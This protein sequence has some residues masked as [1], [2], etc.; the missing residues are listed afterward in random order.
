MDLNEYVLALE[1]GGAP[2][3]PLFIQIPLELS[4]VL[5]RTKE[6]SE[7]AVLEIGYNLSWN[8][9]SSKVEVFPQKFVGWHDGV[10]LNS[11]TAMNWNNYIGDFHVH[12]YRKKYGPTYSIGPSSGDWEGWISNFPNHRNFSIN[13][14]ASGDE[15]FLAVFTQ[16]PNQPNLIMDPRFSDTQ[17]AGPLI[18]DFANNNRQLGVDRSIFTQNG[19]WDD[20]RDLYNTH[21]PQFP[22]THQQ[23]VSEMNSAIAKLN[24]GCVFYEGKLNQ[25]KMTFAWLKEANWDAPT[26]MMA[27]TRNRCVAC[28]ATHGRV[29]SNPFNAWHKCTHCGAVYCPQHGQI[30]EGKGKWYDRTRKCVRCGERTSLA[31]MI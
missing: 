8:T 9:L 12:P 21:V 15:L 6:E 4:Q 26:A 27:L 11:N 22:S 20:L 1:N 30:L 18:Q 23:D 5:H 10:D 25:H 16:R 24:Y 28:G 14:V 17:N 19:R 31:S 7:D 3:Q 13:I 29:P 2:P